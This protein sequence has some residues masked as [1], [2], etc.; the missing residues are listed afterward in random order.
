MNEQARFEDAARSLAEIRGRQGQIIEAVLV[1]AWFWWAVGLLMV[2]LAAVADSG[3]AVA[4]G[5]AIPV[6]VIGVVT[7]S[8]RLAFGARRHVQVRRELLGVRGGLAIVGFVLPVVGVTLG[9]AFALQFG[10]VRYPATI[11]CLAAATALVAGG[12]VLMRVLRR[13][14]LDNRDERSR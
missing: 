5:I 12:P 2:G 4:V 13:I 6:F 9:F 1:P 14:M 8:L 10:G 7:M 11:A 3:S